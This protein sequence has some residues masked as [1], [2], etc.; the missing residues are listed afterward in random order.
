[1]ALQTL[2]AAII[3]GV[4][5]AATKQPNACQISLDCEL[6]GD[7]V[8]GACV[9]DPAWRGKNCEFLALQPAPV[10]NGYRVDG[11]SSWG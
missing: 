3:A 6:N 5:C 2:C 4:A 7:C 1:M 10:Q 9:C 11:T 8:N